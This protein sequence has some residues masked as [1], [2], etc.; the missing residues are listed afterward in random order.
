MM[1][2]SRGSANDKGSTVK[3]A[4]IM[5]SAARAGGDWVRPWGTIDHVRSQ[6]LHAQSLLLRGIPQDQY[7]LLTE[8]EVT[9]I[10]SITDAIR[11]IDRMST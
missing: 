7:P 3:G 11:A 6:L 8:D 9:L 2:Y 1:C 4:K 5:R 10:N